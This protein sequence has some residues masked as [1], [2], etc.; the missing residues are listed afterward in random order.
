M[1]GFGTVFL[2]PWFLYIY[3]RELTELQELEK[4]TSLAAAVQLSAPIV[5]VEMQ[6]PNPAVLVCWKLIVSGWGLPFNQTAAILSVTC[7]CVITH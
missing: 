7:V 4:V 5:S 3:S 1:Q 6:I 2:S